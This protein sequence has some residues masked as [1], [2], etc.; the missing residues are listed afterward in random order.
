MYAIR[1][2][3]ATFGWTIVAANVAPVLTNPGS[4]S[5]TVGTAVS[6]QLVATDGNGDAL[7][8]GATGLPAGLAISAGG[9]ITGTPT[10]VQ[11]VSVTATVSDA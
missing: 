7:T 4:Q 10:T 5:G 11:T 3:Y 9:L 6:L 1:S 2:Y 8:F